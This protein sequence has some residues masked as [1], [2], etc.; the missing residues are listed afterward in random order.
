MKD[1]KKDVWLSIHSVQQFE[2]C[3][4]EEVD[5]MTAARMYRK[6]DKYYISYH[7]SEITGLEGTRTMLKIS[8][9]A[10]SMTRTGSCP[11]EMLFLENQ[12]HVGLYHTGFGTTMTISTRTSRIVNH[13]T[14]D[15]GIL[16]IDYTIEV[17]QNLTG[18]HRFEMVVSTEPIA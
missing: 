2:G 13:I 1:I 4:P 5:M 17:D 11:S 10:V 14:E 6:R 16:A 9:G 8:D 7:E 3:E 15:G 12:R 18:H